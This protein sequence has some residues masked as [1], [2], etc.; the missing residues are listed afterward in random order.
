[1]SLEIAP[2]S[3]KKCAGPK[4]QAEINRRKPAQQHASPN[5]NKS[6]HRHSRAASGVTTFQSGDSSTHMRSIDPRVGVNE[7]QILALRSACACI[8]G[9]CDL[10]SIDWDHL[11]SRARSDLRVASVDA[12][13][14]TMISYGCVA[15]DAAS[16]I[17]AR[18]SE[19]SCSSLYA[20]TIN[21]I[22]GLLSR[23][24]SPVINR[25]ASRRLARALL[26]PG[27]EQ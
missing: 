3:E 5:G 13:S 7:E 20:G 15:P 1:M 8:P 23:A 25:H 22:I 12:S 21:E 17:A 24:I 18:V 11:R 26:C 10:A 6:V 27:V 4:I 9:G 2:C 14:T 19:S 16:R